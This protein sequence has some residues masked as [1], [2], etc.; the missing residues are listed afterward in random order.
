MPL[1]MTISTWFQKY[2]DIVVDCI[3]N[4]NMTSF[5]P[6]SFNFVKNAKM[7]HLWKEV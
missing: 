7:L 5:K 2:N 6:Y 1:N 3:Q 4:F